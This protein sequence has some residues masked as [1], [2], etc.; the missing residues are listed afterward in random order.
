MI[1]S[2]EYKPLED[3]CIRIVY[4]QPRRAKRRAEEIECTL[5]H[6][7]FGDRPEYKA[8][9]YAWGDGT[10]KRI[11]LLDGIKFEVGENLA[12]ALVNIRGLESAGEQQQAIWI[13]AIS[14]NQSDLGERNRQVRLMP[15]IYARA[16]MVIVWLGIAS[17][18]KYHISSEN[19]MY[20]MVTPKHPIISS[21]TLSGQPLAQSLYEG[22]IMTLCKRD[23]WKRLWI[24]QEIGK[25]RYGGLRIHYDF[26]FIEWNRFIEM[27]KS[28]KSLANSIPLKLDGQRQGRFEGGHTLSNLLRTNQ[29]ALCKDP[30]DKI[31]G[32]IGLAVDVHDR[33]PMDYSK[34]PFEV[35]TDTVFFLHGD[36]S[37]SQ[38]D[39]LDMS[40]LVGRMVGG[41]V[42]LEP[43][44][45]ARNFSAGDI[46]LNSQVR[47]L[48]VPGCLVGR[49]N[50]IGHLYCD[51][52]ANPEK[53]N[54]WISLIWRNISDSQLRSTVLEQSELFL[55]ALRVFDE[56]SQR[57]IFAFDRM[58]TWEEVKQYSIDTFESHH[59]ANVGMAAS[60][61]LSLDS[62]RHGSRLF[63][64]QPRPSEVT[65]SYMGLAPLGTQVGDFICHIAGIERAVI[66]RQ[67]TSNN[68]SSVAGRNRY[69]YQIIGCAG[70][71]RDTITARDVRGANLL[72]HELFA[73]GTFSP[74][75]EL[76]RF[77]IYIDIRTAWEVSLFC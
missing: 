16:Q 65:P 70:L 60:E 26:T 4:L 74:P 43:D 39:I 19:N 48:R 51:V 47:S 7:A 42:G 37:R 13:D 35:F 38:H 71:A 44:G 6:V 10:T 1:T 45:L 77:N 12:A 20:A 46:N 54:D 67:S 18:F 36:E 76:E 40:R 27:I 62:G 33:F 11:I 34:S 9:S 73:A 21:A 49:I 59:G 69:T 2:F 61:Q 52:V 25:A 3:D 5:A 23:Y 15:Y 32:F 72:P 58:I 68:P 29:V 41:R 28:K 50:E 55:E 17:T 24:I 8:L 57:T 64:L 14:I 63:L 31:Y 53:S 75:T 56:V 22:K 30:R 66:I